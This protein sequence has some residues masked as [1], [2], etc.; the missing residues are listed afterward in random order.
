VEVLDVIRS[1]AQLFE[2]ENILACTCHGKDWYLQLDLAGQKVREFGQHRD[3]D[4]LTDC[5]G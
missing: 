5:G 3:V 2:D 1:R 4:I